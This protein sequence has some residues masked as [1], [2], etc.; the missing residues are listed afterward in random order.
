MSEHMLLNTT[1]VLGAF[2]VRPSGAAS[3]S[4]VS[5]DHIYTLSVRVSFY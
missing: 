1:D 2:L 5:T 4:G 3:K